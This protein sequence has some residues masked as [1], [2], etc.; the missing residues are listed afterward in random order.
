MD[1]GGLRMVRI[2]RVGA[3]LSLFCGLF[4]H[5]TQIQILRLPR[6]TAHQALA[7]IIIILGDEWAGLLKMAVV[8][9]DGS[10]EETWR[11]GAPRLYA[12][13]LFRIE[14]IVALVHDISYRS[15]AVY[16]SAFLWE[17]EQVSVPWKSL[18]NVHFIVN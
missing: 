6:K 17:H 16:L 8:L 9:L 14:I 15:G 18:C 5:L 3:I 12:W 4:V 13:Q 10:T 11:G 2:I 1:P 7:A